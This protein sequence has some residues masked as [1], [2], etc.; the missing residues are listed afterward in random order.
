MLAGEEDEFVGAI[1]GAPII[2]DK[3]PVKDR[4][5]HQIMREA[6]RDYGIDLGLRTT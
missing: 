1:V 4:D 5:A 3:T 6:I 2:I